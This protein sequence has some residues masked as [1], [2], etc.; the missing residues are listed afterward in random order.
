MFTDSYLQTLQTNFCSSI[1]SP[2]NL[3]IKLADTLQD[4]LYHTPDSR[5]NILIILT[6]FP[7]PS[8]I[9]T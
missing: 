5:K 9:Q 7:L 2:K 8:E 6:A 4:M 3:S 1:V